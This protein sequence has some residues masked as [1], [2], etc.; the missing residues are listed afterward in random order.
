MQ[1]SVTLIP[2]G[3]GAQVTYTEGLRSI[4][5]HQQ[6]VDDDEVAM[7]S[8]GSVKDWRAGHAWAMDRRS[9]ILRYVAEELIR[10]QTA[11]CS[12]EIDE[13]SGQILLRRIPAEPLFD[14]SPD[15][16][17]AGRFGDRRARLGLLAL[18]AVLAFGAGV[19]IKSCVSAVPPDSV[20]TP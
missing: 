18:S 16:I 11:S 12:A 2:R 7:V 15:F 3:R 17:P 19:W 14:G 6:P 9:Q 10:R 8:M 5:G 13:V 4:T 20:R 1:R